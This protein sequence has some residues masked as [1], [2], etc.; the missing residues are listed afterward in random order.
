MP[1][2]SRFKTLYPK[3][4][5]GFTLIELLVVIVVMATLASITMLSYD[6]WKKNTIA[7]QLKNDLN[8]AS[9]AMKDYVNFND[10]YPSALPASVKS[11]EGVV[12]SG[13]SADGKTYCVEASSTVYND[14]LFHITQSDSSA[15]EGNCSS[16]LNSPAAPTV[17][18]T[19]NA[20]N[21]LATA[22]AVTCSAGTAQYGLR[23]RTNDGTWSA[24]SAWSTTRTANQTAN[25]GVKYGYQ[26]QARCYLD[27]T[28]YTLTSTSVEATYIDPITTPATLTVTNSSDATTTTW[29]WTAP[30]CPVGT[31]ARYQ[32][33]YTNSTAY[34]SGLIATANTSVSFTTS[35]GNVTY[36][37]SAQA[38][39]YNANTTSAWNT[40]G[41]ASYYRPITYALTLTAGTGGT[42]SGGG[43]FDAGTVRTIT[44]T[45]STYYS[46]SSWTGSTG[47]SGTASHTITMDA[48]KSCT[49][50]F[51][52]TAIAT[53]TMST[54]TQSSTS[55]TTT[56]SWSAVSC[57]GNSV[58]YQYRYTNSTGYDSGLVGTTNTSV[59]FT[60]STQDV[61][62][63]VAVQAQCYNPVTSSSW[64][65]AKSASYYRPSAG[66][67]VTYNSG[68]G[69][70]TAPAGVTSVTAYVWGAGGSGSGTACS[71]QSGAGG[72]AF[73]TK[74][75]SVTA[76]SSYSYFVGAPSSGSAGGDSWFINSSTVRAKGGGASPPDD[77]AGIGGQASACI[78]TTGAYSGGNGGGGDHASEYGG[79]GGGGAG[80]GGNGGTGGT[81]YGGGGSG[82]S[83]GIGTYPGG[84]GGTGSSP[85][86]PGQSPGGGGGGADTYDCGNGG[87]GGS[88]RIILVW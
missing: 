85:L 51:T 59:T 18:V 46:F 13:G 80:S 66:G 57:P 28:H 61:T 44:A 56:W 54:V 26:A 68:S 70:W 31:S 11:S 76:G 9:L 88:G 20:P 47:C 35:T 45:P 5:K 74:T 24:Y 15:Q 32:Y 37:V 73:A 30:T 78:P 77:S 23:S 55:T 71:N 36:T 82:G 48:N 81:A 39:C 19:L 49:A 69:S 52:P 14:L 27:A 1:N 10:T 65:T 40:A 63:T 83:G 75:I 50:N 16:G 84:R 6:S 62:Y 34:D 2:T 79:G 58:R 22:S 21:V 33:R 7:T 25:D 72:G 67:T 87:L 42:V 43:T 29:S 4:A 60:T 53:P 64:S 12:L 8:N 86:D 41:S 3:I 17:A 38:Q